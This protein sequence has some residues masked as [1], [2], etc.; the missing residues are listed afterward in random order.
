MQEGKTWTYE[1]KKI[2]LWLENPPEM[3]FPVP[4]N[5]PKFSKKSF[6]NYDEMN[7]LKREYLREIAAQ[8]DIK[9]KD[10]YLCFARTRAKSIHARPFLLTSCGRQEASAVSRPRSGRTRHCSAFLVLLLFTRKRSKRCKK[11]KRAFF[12]VKTRKK[13]HFRRFST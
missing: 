11:R 6:R 12:V 4:V 8:G 9:W 5:L 7:A 3:N 1:R 13:R 2:R 10:F